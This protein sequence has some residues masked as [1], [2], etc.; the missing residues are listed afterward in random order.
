V[1]PRTI[2]A[3]PAFDDGL[4]PKQPADLREFDSKWLR[5]APTDEPLVGSADIQS[6]ADLGNSFEV[7][8]GMRW[9]PFTTQTVPQLAITSLLPVVPLT[10]TLISLEQLLERLLKVAF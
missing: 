8:K 5:G 3:S 10:L 2:A 6:L 1:I 7:V 9:V 4:L